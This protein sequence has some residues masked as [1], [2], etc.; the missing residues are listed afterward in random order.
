M[1]A[2]TLRRARQLLAAAR[3][4]TCIT[5]HAIA[6]FRSARRLGLALARANREAARYDAAAAAPSLV[7]E[8]R[9]TEIDSAFR[10]TYLRD[11]EEWAATGEGKTEIRREIV[12]KYE[13]CRR[14][15][16]PWVAGTVQLEGATLIEIGCGTG[17][18]TAAFAQ[19]VERIIGCDLSALHVE[20][21]RARLQAFGIDNAELRIED[22]QTL[23]AS[24]RSE[25]PDGADI[26]LLYAVLE[27]MTLEE[28]LETLRDCWSVLR[29]G[30]VIVVLESPNR[31]L[32]WD[33]HSSLLPFFNMIP[34]ELA[35][36]YF[37]ESP[38]DDFK[39]SVRQGLKEGHEA[40][41]LALTRQGRG[42]SY[43]EFELTIGRLGDKVVADSYDPEI[44]S[45]NPIQL[46]ELELLDFINRETLDIPRA[47][48]RYWI[49]L[50]LRK[51]GDGV[52]RLQ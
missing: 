52:S 14:H 44:A 29:P 19:R 3:N 37:E 33:H 23:L 13:L 50:V 1:P 21:A 51:S 4:R 45:M 46:E 49:D 12:G 47:F 36:K 40:G 17:A 5:P 43:H 16:V 10:L 7:T 18:K 24:V 38:R 28:R 27:H 22:A 15:V 25:V 39:A 48:T 41:L 20:A 31:L 35:L 34:D 30:G 2:V 6:D 32:C 9:V 8:S 42:I 26:C 11:A